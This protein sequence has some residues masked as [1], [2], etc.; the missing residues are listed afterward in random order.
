M[1]IIESYSHVFGA[2]ISETCNNIFTCCFECNRCRK[3]NSHEEQRDSDTNVITS[4]RIDAPNLT[5]EGVIAGSDV[6]KKRMGIEIETSVIKI[7]YSGI[8]DLG[9]YFG[10]IESP[11]WILEEDTSDSTFENTVDNQFR[12]NMEL[13]TCG[14]NKQPIL[15]EIASEMETILSNLYDMASSDQLFVTE[16]MLESI[17]ESKIKVFTK[18]NSKIGFSIKSKPLDPQ[19]R[20]IRPQITYQLSLVQIPHV[21]SYIKER[22]HQRIASFIDD[23]DP[24][25]ILTKIDLSTTMSKMG[26]KNNPVAVLFTKFASNQKKTEIIRNYFKLNISNAMNLMPESR[27]KGFLYLFLHYWYELFNNKAIV[28]REPG[29][30]QSLAIMSRIPL[31]QLFDGLQDIEKKSVVTF[32]T[33]LTNFN[34]FSAKCKLRVYEDYDGK[35]TNPDMNVKQWYESIVNID[36][37]QIVVCCDGVRRN[38]DLLSPPPGFPSTYSMGTLDINSHAGGIALIEVRGYSEIKHN[39]QH[40]TISMIKE[41]VQTESQWFFENEGR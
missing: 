9:F 36:N 11:K 38:L 41:M 18:N 27:I 15:E 39:N 1:L 30:K 12:K 6:S 4:S 8:N 17:L 29:L 31:S 25:I 20:I 10:S 13:K 22:G 32:I 37:R 3:D 34:E 14:G 7:K 21:F 2:G 26:A 28:G 23:L 35:Q 33:G 19:G 16:N 24:S 40:Y 5:K